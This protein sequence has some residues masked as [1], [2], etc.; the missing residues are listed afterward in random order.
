MA[1]IEIQPVGVLP[2]RP[3]VTAAFLPVLKATKPRRMPRTYAL[4]VA[5]ALFQFVQ[6]VFRL[7]DLRE[8]ALSR[9]YREEAEKSGARL[10]GVADPTYYAAERLC[11]PEITR[12]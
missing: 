8:L 5:D 6:M 3:E 12:L 11:Q 2:E 9:N 10:K 7:R 1:P 4:D